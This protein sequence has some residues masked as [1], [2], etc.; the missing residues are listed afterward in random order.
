M[1]SIKSPRPERGSA[2][3]RPSHVI[4]SGYKSNL[5]VGFE[6]SDKERADVIAFLE[7]LTDEE[8]LTNPAF[9]D[10]WVVDD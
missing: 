3:G 5:V 2:W 7:S 9:G 1:R 10:P 8:F 4:A 6:L